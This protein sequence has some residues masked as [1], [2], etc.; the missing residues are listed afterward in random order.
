MR[1]EFLI[2]LFKTLLIIPCFL[3]QFLGIPTIIDK[4]GILLSLRPIETFLLIVEDD[5]LPFDLP[6]N[7]LQ[8]L[9]NDV[10]LRTRTSR[11]DALIRL[12]S[13]AELS[14]SGKTTCREVTNR[15][16]LALLASP[17]K[18]EAVASAHGERREYMGMPSVDV[19][20]SRTSAGGSVSRPGS[21]SGGPA[22]LMIS[23]TRYGRIAGLLSRVEGEVV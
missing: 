23:D 7:S 22:D 2:E 15:S 8:A 18:K 3:H 14:D 9:P 1:Q 16:F 11:R 4:F 5:V 17:R 13:K 21:R 6:V 10:L 12:R 19:K 20:G